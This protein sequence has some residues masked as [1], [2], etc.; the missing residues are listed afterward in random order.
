VSID[1]HQHVALPKLYGQPA[2]ARPPRP[3]ELAERPADVDDLPIAAV[4]TDEE[5]EAAAMLT[6]ATYAERREDG[7]PAEQV[8]G[9]GLRPRPFS[10][11]SIGRLFGGS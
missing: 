10:L 2:Y 1:E 3:V 4:Q 6:G 8:G 7:T 9:R 11:R 5:R